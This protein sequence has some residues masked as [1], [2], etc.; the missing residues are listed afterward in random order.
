MTELVTS[1]V[2]WIQPQMFPALYVPT[3]SA[4]HLSES[5]QQTVARLQ[6]RVFRHRALMLINEAYYQ[7]M[8]VITN[9]GIALPPELDGIRVILGWPRIAVDPYVERLGL[10]SFRRAS[11]T[12]A[13]ATLTDL[14]TATDMDAEEQLA[15]TDALVMGRAWWLVGTDPDGED[16]PD[17]CAESPLNIAAEWDPR[18]RKPSAVLQSYY[19]N[20]RRCAALYLPDQTISL[21]EDDK[22]QWEITNRD[23][24]NLGM[25][26]VV[27]MANRP[28][29]GWRDGM[30]EITPEVMSIT[31]A[32]TRTL[33]NLTAA[34]EFYSVPQKLI[35]G[36]TE[37]DFIKADGD[38]ATAWETYIGRVLALQRDPEGALPE[39]HQ[40]Q[41]YDPAVFTKVIEMYASQMAGVLA[42]PPQ[43]L[44]LYT[45]GNP[46][47]AEAAQVSES[48]RDRRTR[49]MHANFG[50]SLVEVAQLAMRFMNGGELPKEYREIAADWRDPQMVNF[51]GYAD[52]MSKLM[53]EGAIPRG[54]DVALRRL[55]FNA[56]E[57]RQMD[58]ERRANPAEQIIDT[59]GRSVEGKAERM[60]NALV[61]AGKPDTA[62]PNAA[63]GGSTQTTPTK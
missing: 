16:S 5:E 23:Q 2:A 39:V 27:R 53:G 61:A 40:F 4:L 1:S 11:D 9:L 30:S 62:Q 26:P 56:V 15:F 20:D 31:D 33:L 6:A 37:E 17:V 47:S 54:S 51:T 34:S 36:A 7:G 38:K 13:D 57:R 49:R 18:T 28:R 43:D 52:G 22:G 46:V 10:D 12:K 24:H 58:E 45:Q 60:A 63:H 42:A 55:G 29:A 19:M 14:R 32:A 25:V 44:G 48:R 59:L 8:Q 3:L 41:A 50:C 21:S 35:L